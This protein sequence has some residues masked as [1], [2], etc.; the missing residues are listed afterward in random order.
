MVLKFLVAAGVSLAAVTAAQA[1]TINNGVARGA[2]G[3]YAVDVLAGGETRTGTITANSK[4]DGL[5]TSDVI[6]DYF[7]LVNTGSGYTRLS[8]SASSGALARSSE[9][10]VVS[11]GVFTGSGGNEVSWTATSSISAGS[12]I[13][14][15]RYDFSVAS[16]SL[17][18]IGLLQY[19]DEDVRGAGN[20]VFLTRGSAAQSNL[21]LFTIDQ[22]HLMGVSHG[23][24]YSS[25]GGLVNATYSGWAANVY[26]GGSKWRRVANTELAGTIT[27][28]QSKTIPELGQVYGPADVVSALGWRVDPNAT[29]A[30]IITSLGGAPDLASVKPAPS[31]VP[32][33]AGLPL[34]LGAFG[35][36]AGLGRARRA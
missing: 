29:R 13:M 21:Q 8:S 4:I 14:T 9:R 35:L 30:T 17:G 23:G 7:T 26:S 24:A 19:L 18:D 16:G 25:A 3:Y 32:L 11:S 12:P 5:Y 6:Y 22:Q 31:P 15:T 34:M 20:D 28:L 2:L 33:P 1:I 10:Q 27:N 36:L